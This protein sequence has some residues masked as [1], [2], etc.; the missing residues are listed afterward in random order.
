MDVA[1]AIGLGK[2]ARQFR[3]DVLFSHE[4]KQVILAAPGVLRTL[5]TKEIPVVIRSQ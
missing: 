1:A 2:L 4:S 3:L 5:I